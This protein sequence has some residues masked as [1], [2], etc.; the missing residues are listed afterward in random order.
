[1]QSCRFDAVPKG[2]FHHNPLMFARASAFVTW[3]LV[4]AAVVFWILRFAVSSPQAPAYA[5][6]V[7]KAAGLHGDLAR[8]FG[9][10][11][12]VAA[13][14]ADVREAPSRFRLVGV[15]APRAGAPAS[16][17]PHGVALIAVDGKPA[18]AYVVGAR[19]ERDLVLQ[20][21]GLRTAQLAAPGGSGAMTLVVPVLPVAA[22]GVL[23]LPGNGNPA[24]GTPVPI[25]SG[26]LPATAPAP[27]PG[28]QQPPIVL[29]AGAVPP[30]GPPGIEPGRAQ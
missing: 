15:M 4:A 17:E 19:L 27:V 22:T 16:A 29:P 28:I 13:A 5:V 3:S 10:A 8:V 14:A 9:A 20:S 1:M 26:P 12:V 21:V 11:P 23:P 7:A 25:T 24:F 6:P 18:R 30:A 2:A